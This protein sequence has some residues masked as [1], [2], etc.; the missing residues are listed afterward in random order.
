MEELKSA[1]DK[2]NEERVFE[3]LTKID[4]RVDPMSKGPLYLIHL[5]VCNNLAAAEAERILEER[6]TRAVVGALAGAALGAG[7]GYATAKSVGLSNKYAGQV[8]GATAASGAVAGGAAGAASTRNPIDILIF[9]CMTNR[10]YAM[11]Y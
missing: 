1:A 11:L 3:G 10:G 9:N 7:L 4:N 2:F 8:A 6:Q 5:N